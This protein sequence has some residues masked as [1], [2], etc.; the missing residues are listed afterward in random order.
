MEM[1]TERLK[2]KLNARSALTPF[3][4]VLIRETFA[5]THERARL[6]LITF[7][8]KRMYQG[9]R[10]VALARSTS[11]YVA[12]LMNKRPRECVS[13]D[14][15]TDV[16]QAGCLILLSSHLSSTS[17]EQIMPSESK[18]KMPSSKRATAAW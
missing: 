3:R 2:R 16:F 18:P 4:S 17:N 5:T 12:P 15:C 10:F 8:S 13:Y 14:I 7:A 6:L 1:E 11:F 9:A